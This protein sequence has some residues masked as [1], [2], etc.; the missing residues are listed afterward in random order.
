MEF[1]ARNGY[2]WMSAATLANLET[3]VARRS[4]LAALLE[5]QGRSINDTGIYVHVPTHV[6]NAT[7][8]EIC[9]DTEPGIRWF[10]ESAMWYT[11]GATPSGGTIYNPGG[12][13]APFEFKDFYDNNSWF[14]DPE[15]CFGKIEKLY[16]AM[17]P[18]DLVCLFKMGQSQDLLI[19]SM[20][21]FAKEVM[22]RV[23]ELEGAPAVG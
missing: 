23:R 6:A 13:L 10:R 20:E 18:T 5:E 8:E 15:T 2:N 17:R 22:P 21:M 7:H 9:R 12:D 14:G 1:I 16:T 4:Q 19:K 3:V 11:A